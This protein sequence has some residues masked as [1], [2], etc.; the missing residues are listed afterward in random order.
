V[1]LARPWVLMPLAPITG[2]DIPAPR[3]PLYILGD[4]F[5]RKYYTVFDLGAQKVSIALAK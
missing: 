1:A 2:I 3:G 4:I 5:I